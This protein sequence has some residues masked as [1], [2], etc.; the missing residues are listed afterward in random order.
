MG[1][2]KKQLEKQL[3]QIRKFEEL[4]KNVRSQLVKQ[5]RW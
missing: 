5:M 2:T 1:A 3:E 4:E